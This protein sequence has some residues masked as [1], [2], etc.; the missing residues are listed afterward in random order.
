MPVSQENHSF[1]Q[2]MNLGVMLDSSLTVVV[3]N[4]KAQRG[5]EGVSTN[6]FQHFRKRNGNLAHNKT[7]KLTGGEFFVVVW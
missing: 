7:S 6:Y 4:A 3:P 2:T 1:F 5:C